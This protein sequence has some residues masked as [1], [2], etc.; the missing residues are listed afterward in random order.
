M[1]ERRV[2]VSGDR[3]WDDY[4]NLYAVIKGLHPDL[5][6]HGCARGADMMAEQ[7]A[8]A[9]E[10]EYRGYPARW[11]HWR[12]QRRVGAAGPV[13][14]RR[15]LDDAEPNVVAWFH[16][17]LGQSLGTKDMVAEAKRRGIF[18]IDGWGLAMNSVDVSHVESQ[19]RELGI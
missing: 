17:D 12:R 2:L 15:M 9:L 8:L 19:L 1:A 7:A 3:N 4:A 14:N 18:T 11:D 5:I 13:R 10:I 16:K 6:I